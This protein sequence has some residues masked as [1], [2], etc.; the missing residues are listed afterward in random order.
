MVTRA[1]RR[2][3]WDCRV[4]LCVIACRRLALQMMQKKAND[5]FLNPMMKIF[6]SRLLLFVCTFSTVN[7]SAQT[8][9]ERLGYPAGTKLVIIHADDLGETHAVNAAAI[10]TL[11][12]GAINSASIMVPCPW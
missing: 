9:T 5:R 6:R 7:L 10:K 2:G 11:E 3:G 1:R 4:M 8:L 12:T